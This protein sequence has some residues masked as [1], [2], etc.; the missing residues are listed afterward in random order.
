MLPD[1]FLFR[2]IQLLFAQTFGRQ[3]PDFVEQRRL[4]R[5]DFLRIRP[6]IKRKQARH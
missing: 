2:A 1:R 5:L 6:E 3:F 4:H